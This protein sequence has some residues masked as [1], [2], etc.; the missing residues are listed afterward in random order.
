MILQMS[1]DVWPS[2]IPSG[3]SCGKEVTSTV[4]TNATL[5]TTIP[6][7]EG[8]GSILRQKVRPQITDEIQS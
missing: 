2:I 5:T 1:H 6:I 3:D 7:T 8:K 4:I